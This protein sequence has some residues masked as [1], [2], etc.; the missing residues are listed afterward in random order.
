MK[1]I[2]ALIMLFALL[3]TL[4]ACGEKPEDNEAIASAEPTEAAATAEADPTEA[5]LTE[6]ATPEP[7]EEPTPEPTEEV[8]PE[9]TATPEPTPVPEAVKI[10][11]DDCAE[12]V[13]RL[14]WGS[15]DN[16]VYYEPSHESEEIL[17]VCFNVT[18]GKIYLL[19]RWLNHST[20]P[21][22]SIDIATGETGRIDV[23]GTQYSVNTEF[24]IDGSRLITPRE[25]YDLETG[26]DTP[27]Q[28]VDLVQQG[29][30][31]NMRRILMRGG[32]CY[33]YV[34]DE[35]V[36]NHQST[37]P[38]VTEYLLMQDHLSSYWKPMRQYCREDSHSITLLESG[39]SLARGTEMGYDEY[40][41]PDAKGC[42]YVMSEEHRLDEN[43]CDLFLHT[44]SRFTPE[45]YVDVYTLVDMPKHYHYPMFG[46]KHSFRVDEDGTVWFMMMYE[47]EVV[48]YKITL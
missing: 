28:P 47:E 8:T 38:V 13:A 20:S 12:V 33:M 42:H 27:L 24:A 2:V 21:I 18:D 25:I 30:L 1:R 32:E 5:E 17:P 31:M 11:F 29:A 15:G 34:A 22:L 37:S 44:L 10:A 26:E 35:F 39:M 7:T 23:S 36:N 45:G 41:G 6:A 40:L 43:G 48:F 14:P 46:W 4:C 19:D 3:L 16:E 9:P